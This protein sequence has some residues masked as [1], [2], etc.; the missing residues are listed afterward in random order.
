MAQFFALPILVAY[1][2]QKSCRHAWSDHA[3]HP[4]CRLRRL[5]LRTHGMLYCHCSVIHR[6]DPSWPKEVHDNA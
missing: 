3:G 2:T 4:L 1:A 5:S 6:G